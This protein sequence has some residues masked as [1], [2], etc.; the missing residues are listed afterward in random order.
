VITKQPV[1]IMIQGPEPGSIFALPDN[2]VTTIGRSPRNMLPVASDSV[3]RFHCEIAWVNGHWELND[4][5]SKKGTVVNGLAV[6]DK[7]V[8]C[9]G[10]LVRL[11]TTV[12]R[13]DMVED[14]TLSDSDR[15]AIVDAGRGLAGASPDDVAHS[16]DAIRARSRMGGLNVHHE[17]RVEGPSR[18][19]LVFIA[20]SAAA[21]CLLAAGVLLWAHR[22]ADARAAGAHAEARA[23]AARS[24]ALWE[25][26]EAKMALAAGFEGD[27]SHAEALR[28]YDEIEARQPPDALRDLV[29]ELRAYTVRL[30][31]ARFAELERA[32]EQELKAGHP[33]AAVA[34]YREAAASVGVPEL[35][36]TARRRIAEL[37]PAG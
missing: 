16:L 11:S 19:S 37:E 31:H 3:S 25:E 9:P 29:R 5:N 17:P 36:A 10:D 27:G 32:A 30:A 15:K 12:F 13:F 6:D 1:L 8:L 35:V 23:E 28:L 18:P 24:R 2:R 14:S 21:V 4:L 34:Y 7:H 20:G 26:A 33:Q 22:R